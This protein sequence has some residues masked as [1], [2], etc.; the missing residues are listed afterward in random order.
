MQNVESSN[1]INSVLINT[2]NP[3]I[4]I[5]RVNHNIHLSFVSEI[6][7]N[8]LNLGKIKRIQFY[9][10]ADKSFKKVF[11]YFDYWNNSNFSNYFKEEINNGSILKIVYKQPWFWKCSINKKTELV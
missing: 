10:S 11:I 7:E 3:S 5:P 6:F 1:S 2:N 8:K 9:S 4:C